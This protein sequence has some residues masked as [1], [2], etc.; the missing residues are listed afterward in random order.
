M[1]DRREGEKAQERAR[2][3]IERR[4]MHREDMR[5]MQLLSRRGSLNSKYLRLSEASSAS[6]AT[7]E[8]RKEKDRSRDREGEKKKSNQKGERNRSEE[9]DGRGTDECK[10]EGGICDDTECDHDGDISSGRVGILTLSHPIEVVC[11]PAVSLAADEAERAKQ[12]KLKLK[13]TAAMVVQRN[14]MRIRLEVRRKLKEKEEA[15]LFIERRKE[16]QV[17]VIR[18]DSCLG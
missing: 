13:L 14:A 15:E 5:V 11:V 16:L 12:K 3:L 6:K 1:R 2:E 9:V 17:Q 10:V 18:L 4:G 7:R 8:R